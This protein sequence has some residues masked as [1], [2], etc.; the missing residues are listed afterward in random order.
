MDRDSTACGSVSR[1][2]HALNRATPKGQSDTN[3]DLVAAT[4]P[5]IEAFFNRKVCSEMKSP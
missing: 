5:L 4:S 1:K 3:F 2:L